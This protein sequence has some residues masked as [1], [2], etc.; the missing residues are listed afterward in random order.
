MEPTPI[1]GDIIDAE[2]MAIEY[3]Q[4]LLDD[5]EMVTDTNRLKAASL[6]LSHAAERAAPRRYWDGPSWNELT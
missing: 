1:F 2:Y 5:P 4:R 6:L 3:L